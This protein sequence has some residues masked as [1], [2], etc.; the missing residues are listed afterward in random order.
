M[1]DMKLSKS[2]YWKCPLILEDYPILMNNYK[3]LKQLSVTTAYFP[4]FFFY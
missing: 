1:A 3:L 4:R 2:K